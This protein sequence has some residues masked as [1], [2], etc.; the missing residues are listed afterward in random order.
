MEI[1]LTVIVI[2]AIIAVVWLSI[3]YPTFRKWV[4]NYTIA[5]GILSLIAVAVVIVWEAFQP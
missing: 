2:A 3:A 5:A 1:I 4:L